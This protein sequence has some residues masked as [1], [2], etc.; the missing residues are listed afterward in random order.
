MPA[1][2]GTLSA[3]AGITLDVLADQY[4]LF[5]TPVAWGAGVV[6]A[7]A[8]VIGSKMG[9]DVGY[10]QEVARRQAR[11]QWPDQ[12]RANQ[13]AAEYMKNPDSPPLIVS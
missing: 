8:S 3:G 7:A 13:R 2:K 5:S 9:A 1:L 10:M 6:I 11:H 4:G 12:L